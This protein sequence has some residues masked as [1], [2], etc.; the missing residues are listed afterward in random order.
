[1]GSNGYHHDL[2]HSGCVSKT[3]VQI[4]SPLQ[5]H[6]R[7]PENVFFFNTSAQILPTVILM[8]G[9]GWDLGK[10]YIFL[11]LILIAPG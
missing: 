11:Q 5:L 4:S 6:I 1:M 7:I 2:H 9:L 10:Q 3:G 8:D